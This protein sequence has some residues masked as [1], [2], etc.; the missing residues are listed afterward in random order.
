[1]SSQR[2]NNTR[3]LPT[4]S[5][6]ALL[7]LG[8]LDDSIQDAILTQRALASDLE[9]LLQANKEALT[10]KDKVAEADDRL[11]TIEYAKRTVLK[12]LAR[13]KKGIDEK[14]ASIDKRRALMLADRDAQGQQTLEIRRLRQEL[15]ASHDGRGVRRR[16]IANQQRRICEDLRTIYCIA[17]VPGKS[18]TFTIRSLLLPDAD[19]LDDQ[20][21]EKVAAALGYVAHIVTLLSA[22]LTQPLIYPTHARNSSST[23]TDLISLLKTT[24]PALRSDQQRTYP[25]FSQGVPRF[26]FEYAVFLLNKNIQLLLESVYQVRGTDVRQTLPNLKYLLYV[27]TAGEGELPERK[28]GGVKGLIGKRDER[29]GSV[30]S[31]ASTLVEGRAIESLR[32]NVKVEGK[33]KV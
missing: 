1:M 31:R 12:Q 14:Q 7:R 8:K 18:L 6:D 9:K 20:P 32:R 30:D 33:K 17:P 28:A 26:R 25:L 10:L 5:F 22:Y 23:I 2:T 19:G 21:P 13:A 3:A 15:P 27:A 16:A 24:G 29:E 4:S 11:K